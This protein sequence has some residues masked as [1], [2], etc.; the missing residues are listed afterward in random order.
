MQRI[1]VKPTEGG[2]AVKTKNFPA[3]ND[4]Y[5]LFLQNEIQGCNYVKSTN[6]RVQVLKNEITKQVLHAQVKQGQ[7]FELI[8]FFST[9][10]LLLEI[11]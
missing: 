10:I 1:V 4:F 11:L 7:N 9:I 6:I 5:Q 8:E 2:K 3:K